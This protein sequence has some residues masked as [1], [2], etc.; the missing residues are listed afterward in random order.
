[1]ETFSET[2]ER[3]AVKAAEIKKKAAKQKKLPPV[4]PTIYKIE[5]INIQK[6]R[7]KVI[8]NYSQGET[9]TIDR[10][11][12]TYFITTSD[13]IEKSAVREIANIVNR[14]EYFEESVKVPKLYAVRALE[15]ELK[16]FVR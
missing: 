4:E 5:S 11:G 10:F 7:K 12:L 8:I 13:N 9:A 16:R 14:S 2:L 6:S 1:M 3:Y 15:N